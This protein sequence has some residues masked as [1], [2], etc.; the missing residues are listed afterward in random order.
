MSLTSR[1]TAMPR[2]RYK[3]EESVSQVRQVD[4]LVS[5]G[6]ATADAIRQI[7]VSEVEQLK[8]F[9]LFF[10]PIILGRSREAGTVGGILPLPRNFSVMGDITY[11]LL[12]IRTE[13]GS[14][15]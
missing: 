14:Q 6:K 9:W 3:P 2:K 15:R 12:P 1:R 11:P 7:G 13:S 4:L 5:K 8:L 10:G